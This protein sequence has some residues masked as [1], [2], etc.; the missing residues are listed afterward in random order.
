MKPAALTPIAAMT[1]T[2]IHGSNSVNALSVVAPLTLMT[3][4]VMKRKEQRFSK[5]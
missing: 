5:Q 1:Q 4:A 3:F 2:R